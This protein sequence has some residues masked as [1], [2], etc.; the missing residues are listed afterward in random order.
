MIDLLVGIFIAVTLGV[1]S[2][3]YQHRGLSPKT[4]AILHVLAW[5]IGIGFAFGYNSV[6][7]VFVGLLAGACIGLVTVPLM[8][9]IGPKR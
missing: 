5:S 3:F 1:V 9:A 8:L 4:V 7:N 6:N 2:W